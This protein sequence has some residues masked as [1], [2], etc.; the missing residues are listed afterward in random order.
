[1]NPADLAAIVLLNLAGA[2]TPGPDIVL[3]TRLAT[4]SRRHA[5]AATLGIYVGAFFWITLTVLGAA[6]VLTAFPW[7]L[8]LIQVAGGSWIMFMGYTTARQGW[9]DRENPPLDLDDAEDRLGTTRDSF[10]KGLT[11]NLSNPKIVLFLAALVAPLLPP[12]PSIGTAAVVIFAL[13]FTAFLLFISFSLV[14]STN[15]VRRRL[16]SAGPYIDMGAG[17][18]FI[19][20]GTFLVVRGIVGLGS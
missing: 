10:I 14:V 12:S 17:G 11:T 9:R 3:L 8:E 2:A 6:A 18:F 7:L 13:W 20:A 1:M 16:F 5:I 15:R 4:R 19:A